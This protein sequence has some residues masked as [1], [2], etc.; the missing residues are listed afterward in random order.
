MAGRFRSVLGV[1]GWDGVVAAVRA[2]R[3]SAVLDDDRPDRARPI[4]V[5][6]QPQ[7]PARHG[8]VLFGADP[9]DGDRGHLVVEVV[10]GN[11]STLVSGE[12]TARHL[13]LSRS[14]RR[15]SSLGDGPAPGRRERR[16]TRVVH[17]R[18]RGRNALPLAAQVRHR[19]AVRP[20]LAM[21]LVPAFLMVSTIRFRSV[22]AIDMGW[23]RSYFGLFLAAVGLALIA[24]HPRVAL[25]VLSYVYLASAFIGL[26]Y[27]RLRKRP[28][29]ESPEASEDIAHTE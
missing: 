12:A 13:V 25:V 2:V 15:L 9:V 27:S 10:P 24:T 5:L 1:H 6:V 21:V 17:W 7:I 23:R 16:A 3:D 19:L 28:V 14:G 8:G 29:A 22:K 26:A 20:A 18:S 4:A 11:P